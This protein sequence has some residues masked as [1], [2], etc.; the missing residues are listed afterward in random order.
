MIEDVW[1]RI[2]VH[3]LHG[4]AMKWF[5]DFPHRSINGI[6]ALEKAF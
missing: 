6:E 4:E 3:R 5:K 2:F 1:M